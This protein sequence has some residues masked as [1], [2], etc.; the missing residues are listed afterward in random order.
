MQ[1]NFPDNLPDSSSD[2]S[3]SFEKN[4][5]IN[6]FEKFGRE[7]F[8]SFVEKD[9][10]YKEIYQLSISAKEFAFPKRYEEYTITPENAPVIPVSAFPI[11][12]RLR[13]WSHEAKENKG[14]RTDNFELI[15]TN[16]IK[17]L[18]SKSA[19]DKKNL[20]VEVQRLI[21]ENTVKEN[22]IKHFIA[23]MLFTYEPGMASYESAL[24]SIENA[25]N[26][27][28]QSSINPDDKQGLIY[29]CGIFK[30]I[31]ALKFDHQ[32]DGETFFAQN[33]EENDLGVSAMYN[34]ATIYMKTDR[35]TGAMP[36]LLRL[37]QRDLALL[38]AAIMQSNILLLRFAYQNASLYTVLRNRTFAPLIE[39]I[40]HAVGIAG[41]ER[42]YIYNQIELWLEK[43][44]TSQLQKYFNDEITLAKDFM[45]EAIN[46]YKISKSRF[47]QNVGLFLSDKFRHILD[48]VKKEAVKKVE[49][50]SADYMSRYKE[51]IDQNTLKLSELKREFDNRR[52]ANEAMFNQKIDALREKFAASIEEQ[53][54]KIYEMERSNSFQPMTVFT[55]GMKVTVLLMIIV[56][57]F[58]GVMSAMS[59]SE[60]DDSFIK[61]VLMSGGKA[62]MVVLIIGI[63]GVMIGVLSKQKTVRAKVDQEKRK[64]DNLMKIT[65]EETKKL[66]KEFDRSNRRLEQTYESS[67]AV[68]ETQG[69]KYEREQFDIQ[70]EYDERKQKETQE[71][72][73]QIRVIFD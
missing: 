28:I 51:L 56:G 69:K 8:L 54:S 33:L 43:L 60:G 44:D 45:R 73:E 11:F 59:G 20:A 34:L 23:A 39:D 7:N 72:E 6:S 40:Q 66:K 14:I 3:F 19:Q 55:Q 5:L 58:V 41:K 18:E 38:N 65:E 26:Q 22:I 47:S 61:V 29:H 64:L 49:K 67:K 30:G 57:F 52:S 16:Y 46:T 12:Y 62:G 10:G 15:E 71:I 50:D 4:I 37:Y 25:R 21:R 48:L 17:W 42:S 63:I 9:P 1:E 24:N 13:H 31:I 2:E 32:V 35:A 68:M 70:K 36:L 53:E 27:I